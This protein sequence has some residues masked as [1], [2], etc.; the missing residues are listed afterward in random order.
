MTKDVRWIVGKEMMNLILI[1]S[2]S[3]MKQTMAQVSL[4]IPFPPFSFK[5]SNHHWV[6]SSFHPDPVSSSSSSEWMCD[7]APPSSP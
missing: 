4:L 3:K 1:G 7:R 2:E 6:Y 5:K